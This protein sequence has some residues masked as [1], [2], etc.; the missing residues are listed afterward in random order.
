MKHCILRLERVRVYI[1]VL[2][3]AD[4]RAA[5]G[6]GVTGGAQTAQ[7]ILVTCMIHTVQLNC[8]RETLYSQARTRPCLYTG[9][10]AR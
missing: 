1:R 3:L 4:E 8:R 10:A 7:P 2:Q 9:S 6:G 5:G